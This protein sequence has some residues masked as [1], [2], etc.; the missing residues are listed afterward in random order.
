MTTVATTTSVLKSARTST[1][2]V[3][4]I[5]TDS[6]NVISQS[7]SLATRGIDML[8]HKVE[9]VYQGVITNEKITRFTQRE[10]LLAQAATRR[11]DLLERIH[12]DNKL[13]GTFN[14]TEVYLA[15]LDEL[16]QALAD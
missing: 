12:R 2:S 16:A 8:D 3:F 10:D 7:L 13:N 14:R 11:T 1:N 15:C 4:A 6:A 9:T 5:V